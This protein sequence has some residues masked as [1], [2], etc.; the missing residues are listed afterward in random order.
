MRAF[1]AL[2]VKVQQ[3]FLGESYLTSLY[4][5]EA[6]LCATA[7]TSSACRR[8]N[9]PICAA[10][11]ALTSAGSNVV[12]GTSRWSTSRRLQGPSGLRSV[13][14]FAEFDHRMLALIVPKPRTTSLEGWVSG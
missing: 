9:L 5:F 1:S 3:V 11:T 14:C 13:N 4:K 7:V 10:S 8:R 12:N 2:Q 6:R